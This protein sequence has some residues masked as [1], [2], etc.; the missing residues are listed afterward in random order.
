MTMRTATSRPSV[1]AAPRP[2]ALALAGAL[3]AASACASNDDPNGFDPTPWATAVDNSGDTTVIRIT[4]AVPE[5][6]VRTLVTEL[7][8]GAEDGSEEEM[9]GSVTTVLGTPEGGLLVY[10]Q[11]AMTVRL[12]DAQGAFVRTVGRAAGGPGEYEHLNGIARL[13]D[14]RLVFWDAAGGRLNFYSPAGEFTSTVRM[15]FQGIFS[16]NIL[17]ADRESRLYARGVLERG[18]DFAT[19]KSGYIR[20]D[21]AGRIIDSIPL[22]EWRPPTGGHAVRRPEQAPERR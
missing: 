17:I 4:G 12:F 11:Q 21:S 16:Q 6:H 8:V 7:E 1:A 10:D 5:S 19:N 20:M 2:V 3:A 22:I 13:G 18:A 15:P 14:D 9:F